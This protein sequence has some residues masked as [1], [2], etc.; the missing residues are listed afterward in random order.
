MDAIVF[1]GNNAHVFSDTML[2]VNDIIADIEFHIVIEHAGFLELR[3]IA[4]Q[5]F[6]F[7]K[8]L[9]AR[10]DDDMLQQALETFRKR[11]RADVDAWFFPI[12]GPFGI[13]QLFAVEALDDRMG[14]RL[15]H[16]QDDRIGLCLLCD[17]FQLSGKGK[18]A[19]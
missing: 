14:I 12:D 7:G 4:H 15:F 6:L 1:P 9:S 5:L 17:G 13:G 2:M 18:F 19:W 8:Q 3:M 11:K 16:A 10:I